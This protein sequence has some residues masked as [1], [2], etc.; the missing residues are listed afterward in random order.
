[1]RKGHWLSVLLL[2][3]LTACGIAQAAPS[4]VAT[5]IPGFGTSQLLKGSIANPTISAADYKVV[6]YLRVNGGYWVKPRDDNWKTTVNNDYSFSLQVVTGGQDEFADQYIVYL[7]HANAACS[8][9]RSSVEAC[10]LSKLVVERPPMDIADLASITASSSYNPYNYL[11]D[12]VVDGDFYTD[13]ASYQ[14]T[15]PWIQF[16]FNTPQSIDSIE[17]AD[18]L[19]LTDWAQ[20]VDIVLN[21]HGTVR[22]AQI[23]NNGSP[24][25]VVVRRHGVKWIRFQIYGQ[26]G[27]VGLSDVK[28]F[29]SVREDMNVASLGAIPASSSYSGSYLAHLVADNNFF[30]EWA[31]RGEINPWIGFHWGAPQ[32]VNKVVLL[33]RGNL[34]DHARNAVLS[35]SD[36]SSVN[37]SDIPN[38]GQAKMVSFAPRSASWMNLQVANG[39]GANVG[40][41][42]IQVIGVADMGNIAPLAT[43]TASSSHR[44]TP[45]EYVPSAAIEG[46]TGNAGYEWA[47]FHEINPWI[48][49]QWTSVRPVSSVVLYDRDNLIDAANKAR[50]TFSDG[51]CVD[52]SDIPN[53]GSPKLVEFPTKNISWMQVNVTDGS[54]AN[55]GFAE[56]VV[57]P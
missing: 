36:G 57:R 33:D 9:E 44:H 13:W 23:S 6:V 26:G 53:D 22:R 55:V 11:P 32:V 31:S 46:T 35:F 21:D 17:I 50:I 3:G 47:S 2:T 1:M 54:G 4:I 34:V 18:R 12:R 52:V 37:V 56:I 39:S 25:R 43:A 19:N 29:G 27:N 42:E 20:N 16:N 30:T 48:K 28:I 15:S 49:L 40:F 5:Q 41:A 10:A 7:I 51:S 24:A 14:E 45:P 8:Q 38:N